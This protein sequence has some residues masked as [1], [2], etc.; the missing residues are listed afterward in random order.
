MLTYANMEDGLKTCGTCGGSGRV[1]DPVF[2]GQKMRKLRK[3]EGKTLRAVARAMDLSAAYLSD[4]ELG[5][6]G[7]S[8]SLQQAYVRG[9][10]R[11]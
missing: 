11:A 6:R 7:W 4:L 8:K 2:V 9:V 10:A 1:P 3:S 5:R